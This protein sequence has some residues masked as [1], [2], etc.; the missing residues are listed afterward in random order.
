M[1]IYF[2]LGISKLVPRPVPRTW[3]CVIWYHNK[4]LSTGIVSYGTTIS[5][6]HLAM[7]HTVPRPV[8]PSN[9]SYGIR[10]HLCFCV[11]RKW[12]ITYFYVTNNHF[13]LNMTLLFFVWSFTTILFNF[14]SIDNKDGFEH[15]FFYFFL[16]EIYFCYWIH[17]HVI[18]GFNLIA[19]WFIK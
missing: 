9:M 12:K 14:V 5:V 6:F 16:I 18:T 8:Q 1:L 10:Q 13:R 11:D 17:R 7:C 3:Q 4:C 15:T 2:L 19:P